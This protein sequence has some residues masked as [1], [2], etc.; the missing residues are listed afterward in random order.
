MFIL[1]HLVNLVMT[2]EIRDA[3]DKGEFHVWAVETVEEAFE[4]MTGLECG[5]WNPKTEQFLL[6]IVTS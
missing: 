2:K 6:P 5:E 3:I 1:K 4:L